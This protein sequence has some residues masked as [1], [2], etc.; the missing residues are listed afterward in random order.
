MK[1]SQRERRKRQQGRRR[2]MSYEDVNHYTTISLLLVKTRLF[3]NT[4]VTIFVQYLS[5]NK[6][7]AY[8][9]LSLIVILFLSCCV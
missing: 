1:G 2:L 9:L 7:L 8:I 4:P 3:C 6:A 5:L